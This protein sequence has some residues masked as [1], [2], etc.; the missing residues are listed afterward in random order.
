MRV[1]LTHLLKWHYAPQHETGWQ[2]TIDEQREH[3]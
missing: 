2:I 3:L 1:L